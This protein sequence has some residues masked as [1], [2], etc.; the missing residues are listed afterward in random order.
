MTLDSI[1]KLDSGEIEA[2]VSMENLTQNPL[3]NNL[4]NGNVIV[5]RGNANVRGG[6]G[7]NLPASTA[8]A[9]PTRLPALVDAL[10]QKLPVANVTRES[11]NIINGTFARSL[12]VI[13]RPNESNADPTGAGA[14]WHT[15]A[16][17]IDVRFGSRTWRCR[18]GGDGRGTIQAD[19]VI[20][21]QPSIAAGRDRV[22][23][24][25]HST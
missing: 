17:P 16:Y 9:I 10:G 3:G 1:R 14:V 6:F 19:N 22:L 4:I 23:H 20:Q 21:G 8:P 24:D 15:D 5:V 7:G 13:Y 25:M 18:D 12:T 2:Q 11:T